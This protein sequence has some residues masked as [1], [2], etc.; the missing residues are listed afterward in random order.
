MKQFKNLKDFW[1]N[2]YIIKYKDCH[3]DK[4]TGHDYIDSYYTNIL[5]SDFKGTI[6]EIGI[7]NGYSSVLWREWM[8]NAKLIG[9][10]YQPARDDLK[11]FLETINVDCIIDDGYATHVVSMFD[12]ESIDILIDD[13]P[14]TLESQIACIIKWFPKVKR[15]GKLI[16]EDVQSPEWFEMLDSVAYSVSDSI[17]ITKIDIRHNKN[18]WDDLIYEITKL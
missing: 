1:H 12:D 10:E 16:I 13:G 17:L 6:L 8:P 3:T 5:D 15:G 11:Q 7:Q 2:H 14:H 4:G 9:I 18:R